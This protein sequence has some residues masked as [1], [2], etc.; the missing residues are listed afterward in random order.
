MIPRRW[1]VTALGLLLVGLGVL[2]ADSDPGQAI[3]SGTQG[4]LT[5]IGLVA[6][7]LAIWKVRGSLG[8]SAQAAP[9]PWAADDPFATPAPER[10]PR[11]V[12]FASETLARLVEEACETARRKGSV[13]AGVAV[14]RPALR[15]ALVDALLQG[16]GTR[17]RADVESTL[18]KGRWTDD[19]LAASVLDEA[20]EPP[21]RS[22][23]ER[24]I[25][26][27][28]PQRT[29]RERTRRAMQAIAA[30]ADDSLAQVPGQTA[31]R[32]LPV[33]RP[34]L[35]ELR[36]GT[37]GRLQHAVDPL[38][39][40]RSQTPPAPSFD[41]VP[42]LGTHS[43]EADSDSDPLFEAVPKSDTSTETAQHSDTLS[44]T[45]P[46]PDAATETTPN[47]DAA[48]ETASDSNGEFQTNPF[49]E[50]RIDR[51]RADVDHHRSEGVE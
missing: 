16:G 36:R 46:N 26:W 39:V 2:L 29:V 23:R 45:T 32:T 50:D 41:P 22:L 38:A 24:L 51:G 35:E 19:R 6:I 47:P 27:L 7:A 37:D 34:R 15:E 43:D 44:E 11:E 21:E 5:L 18:A 20:V 28:S 33:V 30:L 12:R 13:D 8:A 25:D 17:T 3:D 42:S 14:V 49:G 40:S 10:T 48:T 1:L 4:L 9:V 31:L